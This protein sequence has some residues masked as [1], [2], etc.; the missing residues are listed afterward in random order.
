MVVPE[1]TLSKRLFLLARIKKAQV[2]LISSLRRVCLSTLLL[3]LLKRRKTLSVLRT[4]SLKESG[5]MK[6][7]RTKVARVSKESHS[8]VNARERIWMMCRTSLK[9]KLLKRFQP[10]TLPLLLSKMDM[11]LWTVT[12]L[13]KPESS[14]ARCSAKK[15]D[16]K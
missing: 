4:M 5:L 1:R 13:L 7:K 9:V 2:N 6:T 10:T 14:L 3:Q 16:L 15:T 8:W 12:I 11:T